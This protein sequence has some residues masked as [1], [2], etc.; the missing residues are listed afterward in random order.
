MAVFIETSPGLYVTGSLYKPSPEPADSYPFIMCPHMHTPADPGSGVRPH[1][2]PTH[3]TPIPCT[4]LLC[5]AD[6]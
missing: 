1:P 2:I 5:R 4:Y 6:L 3:P